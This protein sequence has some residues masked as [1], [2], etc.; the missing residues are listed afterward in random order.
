MKVNIGN[1]CRNSENQK[2][3]IQIDPWDTWNMDYTLAL[4][5]HPMLI[6]LKETSHGTPEVDNEDVPEKLRSEKD[7]YGVSPTSKD[8][9]NYVMDKMIETFHYLSEN[10][11]DLWQESLKIKPNIQYYE[12]TKEKDKFTKEKDKMCEEGLR[13]F[14]KYYRA[15]WD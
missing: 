11:Y 9:W 14:G 12:F 13:L 15:L 3:D 8:K 7:K 5:I 1:Y 4:I 6:Q 10:D 2:I